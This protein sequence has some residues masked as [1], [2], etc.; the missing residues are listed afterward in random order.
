MTSTG[1]FNLQFINEKTLYENNNIGQK[2]MQGFNES[3]E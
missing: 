1:M 3:S 2:L